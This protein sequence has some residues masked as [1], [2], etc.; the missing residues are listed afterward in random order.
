MLAYFPTPFPDEL[1]YS[2]YARYVERVGYFS[3]KAIL[4]DTFGP[5][6]RR[7]YYDLPTHLA[8]FVSRLPPGYA[9]S[10]EELIFKHTLYPLYQPFLQEDQQLALREKMLNGRSNR[11]R[12]KSEQINRPIILPRCLRYCPVCVQT[13]ITTVGE[14][15]WHRVHQ[16]PGVLL[17]PTHH[18]WLEQS[19]VSLNGQSNQ[20]L[21]LSANIGIGHVPP[22]LVDRG[23]TVAE[24][25]MKVASDVEWLLN[26]QNLML[27]PVNLA[28]R[29]RDM[30]VNIGIGVYNS[31]LGQNG[32][33]S[34]YSFYPN[35][36]FALLVSNPNSRKW[37]VAPIHYHTKAAQSPIVHILLMQY[38]CK[39]VQSFIQERV[40]N[41]PFIGPFPCLNPVCHSFRQP[42]I[43]RVNI[44]L[45]ANR[46]RGVFEC[47][48]C[49]YTYSRHGP[50]TND[51]DR[52]QPDKIIARGSVWDKKLEELWKSKLSVSAIGQILG[53]TRHAVQSHAQR[54][55]L[56]MT[57]NG[58]EYRVSHYMERQKAEKRSA[59]IAARRARILAGKASFL[60]NP[61]G[62]FC[63]IFSRDCQFLRLFDSTWFSKLMVELRQELQP[64][65]RAGRAD[66][67][68]KI[69]RE[70]MQAI[71]LAANAQLMSGE[72]PERLTLNLLL[73]FTQRSPSQLRQNIDRLP[74]TS[75]YIRKMDIPESFAAFY[76][77][78]INWAAKKFTEEG[79]TPAMSML[80]RRA[81]VPYSASVPNQLLNEMLQT[82]INAIASTLD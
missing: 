67:W 69:D 46:A 55:D 28:T 62:S 73:G 27:G 36:L 31:P 30:L 47:P 32:I 56:P 10:A 44:T 54:L 23:D 1:F 26:Q 58:F 42:V 72:K 82:A 24:I 35:E 52:Y 2:L 22:R 45:H 6:A 34:I 74:L 68:T 53:V 64:I 66:V 80:R 78:K 76:L 29:Y 11:E 16:A 51:S 20:A 5:R 61:N 65:R 81:G 71:E 41:S 49:G 25:L 8:D 40:D 75:A 14:A 4:Q 18:I 12:L 39:D 57:R 60:A 48:S 63:K 50:E 15:Y 17:C 9:Y 59:E 77:R 38:F 79:R 7:L 13:D 37:L 43:E 3:T 19:A 33:E 21:A 70:V